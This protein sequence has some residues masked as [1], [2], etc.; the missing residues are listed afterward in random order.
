M[1]HE[2]LEDCDATAAVPKHGEVDGGFIGDRGQH[3]EQDH[4]VGQAQPRPKVVVVQRP[5]HRRLHNV[6]T[7]PHAAMH[8]FPNDGAGVRIPGGARR[9]L[10]IL[11]WAGVH[12]QGY[13]PMA[14]V[15]LGAAGPV[16]R[17]ATI[18]GVAVDERRWTQF[19]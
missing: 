8:M 3:A 1:G 6:F 12:D 18:C 15:V 17:G 11:E 13:A 19:G 16:E 10:R 14:A 2:S 4:L 7:K 9:R 5:I